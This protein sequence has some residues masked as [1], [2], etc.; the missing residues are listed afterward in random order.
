MLILDMAP[1]ILIYRPEA[2]QIVHVKA[3]F[4]DQ[5]S[6]ES[7]I[8]QAYT[9]VNP[10]FQVDQQSFSNELAFYYDILFGD[11]TKIT[12]LATLLCL[13]IACF[14]LLG[15]ATYSIE[16]RTKE[17]GIRKVLGAS[18]KE[19]LV[20]LSKSY[21]YILLIAII[22]ALPIAYFANN[23]WLQHIAYRVEITAEVISLGV[24]L[25]IIL[26]LITISTQTYR[27]LKI[28][29]VESLKNE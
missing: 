7:R 14:G 20:Q 24:F 9:T 27:A 26:G 12:A 17:V 1:M 4:T 22:I 29:P 2:T 18:G 5:A 10:G 11:I 23:L 15:M 13:I 8:K 25:L 21:V 3:N 19:L 6:V 16:T 28:N